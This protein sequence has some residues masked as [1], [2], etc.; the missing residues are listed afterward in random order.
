MAARCK[1]AKISGGRGSAGLAH[2]MTDHA[3]AAFPVA[4]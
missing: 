4:R 2:A 1:Y 3:F